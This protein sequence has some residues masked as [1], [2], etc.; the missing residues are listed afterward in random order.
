MI[1]HVDAC[2]FKVRPNLRICL[3]H[4]MQNL[5]AAPAALLLWVDTMCIDQTNFL[6]RTE[7]VRHMGKAYIEA[8]YG[9]AWLGP[10]PLVDSNQ[11]IYE[12]GALCRRGAV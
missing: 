3:R 2:W 8:T 10:V 7:Q 12:Y 1:V 11:Y 6:E 4:L 9:S 5:S